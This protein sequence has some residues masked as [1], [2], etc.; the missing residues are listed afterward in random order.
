M[1]AGRAIPDQ[2]ANRG[3]DTTSGAS[4]E[5]CVIVNLRLVTSTPIADFEGH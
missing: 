5:H 2:A 1:S 4:G 3:R